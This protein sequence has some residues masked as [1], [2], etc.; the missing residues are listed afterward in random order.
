MIAYF[1]TGT[2]TEV[3]KTWVTLGL[4][5]ALQAKG[6]SVAGMKP[7]ASGCSVTESGLRNDDAVKIR[8]QASYE[9]VYDD[10]NPYSYEPPIA[11]HVAAK[12][13]GETIQ[14]HIIDASYRR[15]SERVDA[16]VVEGIGGWRVPFGKGL[17]TKDLV[18]H[19]QI[20]VILVVGLRLGC[21]NH[22][23]L[24]AEAIAADGVQL[25]GWVSNHIDPSY[26]EAQETLEQLSEAIPAPLLGKIPHLSELDIEKV[27]NSISGYL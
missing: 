14:L 8:K 5:S 20:P 27:A 9:A 21:I 7:I 22:A 4:M 1:V 24:S 26:I 12:Q 19:L 3:G 15:L 10:I 25:M 13:I 11:P 2:D 17:Q 6:L 23:L 18:K 16:I